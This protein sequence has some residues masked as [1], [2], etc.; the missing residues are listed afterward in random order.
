MEPPGELF[1]PKL[2]KIKKQNS[3]SKKFLILRENGTFREISCIFSKERFP[4][5]SKN[6]KLKKVLYT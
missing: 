4:Y 6:E 2:E 5:I 1:K 3:T